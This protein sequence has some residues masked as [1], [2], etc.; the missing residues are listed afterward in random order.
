MYLRTGLCSG[1]EV[2]VRKIQHHIG[3]RSRLAQ[4]KAVP[5]FPKPG[6]VIWTTLNVHCIWGNKKITVY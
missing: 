3:T 2:G 5:T 4:G 6:K 1:L